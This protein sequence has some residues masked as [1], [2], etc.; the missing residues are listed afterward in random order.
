[1]SSFMQGFWFGALATMV[2]ILGII[3]LIWH[4]VIKHMA[5]SIGTQLPLDPEKTCAKGWH[6]FDKWHRRGGFLQ[7]D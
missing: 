3:P 4:W 1:M 5:K 6:I 7:W 2:T